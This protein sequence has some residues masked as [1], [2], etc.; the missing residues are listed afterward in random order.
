M[1]NFIRRHIQYFE[2]IG[3]IMR[4][5]SFSVVSFMGK[6]SPFVLVWVVNSVDALILAWCSIL[7]KDRAYTVLNIFWVIVGIFGIYQTL[8]H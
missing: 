7:K 6:E 3:V 4:I 2:L 8:T 5:M 1:N